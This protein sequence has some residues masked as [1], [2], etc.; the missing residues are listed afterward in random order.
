MAGKYFTVLNPG[1]SQLYV[2]DLPYL[3]GTGDDADTNPLNPNDDR[4][5][6]EGEWLELTA[7]SNR[8]RFTRGGDNVVTV[9]GTPDGEGTNPAFPFF[10]E[11]GR[12]DA[13]AI[14]MVH[15]IMGPAFYE[16]RTKLCYSSG[17]VVN[18]QVSVFDW[19]GRSGAYGVNRRVL[20]ETSSGWVVGRVSR[21]YGDDDIAVIYGMQ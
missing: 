15:C 3:A 21:I 20:Y 2:R 14:K 11:R 8:P 17:L 19:D 6:V 12:T 13:Q 1:Y 10:L 4:A 5:L 16:F 7:T 9:S 18:D